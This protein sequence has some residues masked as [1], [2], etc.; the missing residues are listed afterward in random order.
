[1]ILLDL[2]FSALPSLGLGPPACHA[3]HTITLVR[4]LLREYDQLLLRDRCLAIKGVQVFRPISGIR[5]T[6]IVESWL[7]R[8]TRLRRDALTDPPLLFGKRR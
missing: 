4:K 3:N 1:M 6:D 5:S 2:V 7:D 8:A